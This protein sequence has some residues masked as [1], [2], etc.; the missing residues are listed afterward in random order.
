MICLRDMFENRKAPPT[1]GTTWSVGGSTK[2]NVSRRCCHPIYSKFPWS[3]YNCTYKL[4]TDFLLPT[5]VY[6]FL[7][8]L[9]QFHSVGFIHVIGTDKQS[10]NVF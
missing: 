10:L 5:I 2:T 7:L 3:L 1:I 4:H 9:L 6:L 8:L